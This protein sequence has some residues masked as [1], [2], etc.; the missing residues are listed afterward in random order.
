MA[1]HFDMRNRRDFLKS[2]GLLSAAA[3]AASAS[4]VQ[5]L[6][7][8]RLGKYS[9]SRLVCGSNMFGG[10]SHSSIFLDKRLK[11]YYTPERILKTLRRCDELGL[12]TWQTS[13]GMVALNM[14]LA[15]QGIKMNC[16]VIA[17]AGETGAYGGQPVGI[18]SYVKAG[19]IGIA[20]HGEHSDRLFKTGKIAEMN[21][22]LK[23]VRDAGLLVG[24][25]THMPAVVDIVESKGWDVDYYMTCVYERHRSADELK[26]L[27]GYVPLPV[28]E[29]YLR[30]DP[31]RMFRMIRQTKR[32]CFAFKI[33]A[34]GRLSNTPESV[35]T[36]F[37][38]T[39]AAIKPGDGVIV[40]MYDEYSD[41]PLANAGY[42]RKY[43]ARPA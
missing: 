33:L 4:A 6:P 14:K 42:A 17:A 43:G 20:H 8:L 39:F 12:N 40:G 31:E 18:D 32:P 7:Q 29:V 11:D 2:G 24:V 22:Y 30:E 27:L 36:A 34:A 9:I 23:R 21:E 28:G 15:E 38:D 1:D 3:V 37:R 25:S 10:G 16:M 13:G 41:Q 5:E 19:C 35:E 26:K